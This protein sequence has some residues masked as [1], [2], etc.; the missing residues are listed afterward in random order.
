M[1]LDIMMPGEDGL[2]LCR[3][4]P[5]DEGHPGHPA[6][7]HGRRDRP[8]RRARGGRRRLRGEA[9][10][11]ARA[12]GAHQ[13][14]AAPR[15]HAAAAAAKAR[16]G[17]RASIAGSSILAGASWS[18]RRTSRCRCRAA[19]SACSR[20]CSSGPAWCYARPASRPDARA[21]RRNPSTAAID[22]QISRLR[23][24]I[25]RRPAQPADHQDRVGR[26]LQLCR[27]GE[28]PMRF[29]PKSLAGRLAGSW[30]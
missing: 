13:G 16:R 21:R 25:E 8:H 26:R 6:D 12:A 1:V 28:A 24:K 27:R 9:L 20:C 4:R 10:Q 18:T 3:V 30:C 17:A 2:S 29:L 14:G 19:S 7:R 5:R 22:N 15:A 11:P 23:K